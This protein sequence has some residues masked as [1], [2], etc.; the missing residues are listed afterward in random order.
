MGALH[1]EPWGGTFPQF[2]DLIIPTIRIIVTANIKHLLHPSHLSVK[3]LPKYHLLN[4][5]IEEITA[6][7][8]PSP[9]TLPYFYSQQLSISE[10]LYLIV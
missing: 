6:T 4:H 2:E 8:M 5:P 10:I 3:S 1:L 7:I 9:L